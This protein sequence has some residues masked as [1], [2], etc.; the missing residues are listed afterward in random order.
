MGPFLHNFWAAKGATS[1]S[2][3]KGCPAQ[4]PCQGLSSPTMITR[5]V[6][7]NSRAIQPN[8]GNKGCP[9]QQ[10]QRASQL[11]FLLSRAAWGWVCQSA[12]AKLWPGVPLMISTTDI[13]CVQFNTW[14]APLLCFKKCLSLQGFWHEQ[15]LSFQLFQHSKGLL[16]GWDHLLL[17]ALIFVEL[18]HQGQNLLAFL[19]GLGNILQECLGHVSRGGQA[20]QPTTNRTDSKWSGWQQV[21]MPLWYSPWTRVIRSATG[22]I[23]GNAKSSPQSWICP[24]NCWFILEALELRRFS[25]PGTK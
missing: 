4:L 25:I 12:I 7:P 1:F 22:A 3:N 18:P 5:A 2:F 14:W 19:L 20:C 16:Q 8:N 24:A 6:Q 15:L 9:A 21:H 23:Q 11:T 10:R 17:L 13:W